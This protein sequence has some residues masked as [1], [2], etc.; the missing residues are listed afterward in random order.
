M[1]R[2]FGHIVEADLNLMFVLWRTALVFALKSRKHWDRLSSPSMLT[3]WEIMINGRLESD[4][5]VTLKKP[6]F[7]FGD[8]IAKDDRILYDGDYKCL[9]QIRD[10]R[11]FLPNMERMYPLAYLQHM[12]VHCAMEWDLSKSISDVFL[13]KLGV[14]EAYA[15]DHER[16]VFGLQPSQ[17]A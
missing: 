16:D 8:A 10:K 4:T 15:T 11:F 6:D 2:H 7:F 1:K 12:S 17:D 5:R 14:K 13:G 9:C 3:F